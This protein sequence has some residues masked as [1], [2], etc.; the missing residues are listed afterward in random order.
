MK[1]I[2]VISKL[3]NTVMIDGKSLLFKDTDLGFESD[4]RKGVYIYSSL[5]VSSYKRSFNWLC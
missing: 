1:F 2:R 5:S 3:L 4:S